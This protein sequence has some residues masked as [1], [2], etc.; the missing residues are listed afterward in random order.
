MLREIM[1]QPGTAQHEGIMR[2]LIV[3]FFCF[4]ASTTGCDVARQANH[5]PL[6]PSSVATGNVSIAEPHRR[7]VSVDGVKLSF[8]EAGTGDPVLYVHGVVTTSNIFRQYLDAYSP[9]F[10]GIAVDLRGYGDSEKP[11][12]GFTIKQFSKD[13]IALIDKLG[14]D[15]A[16][17]VGVSMGG[18][19]CSS[20]PWTI[21]IGSEPWSWF[22]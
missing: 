5:V 17:W 1:T 7:T 3:L 15:K 8:L 22:R 14:I 18:M 16:V 11:A 20:L 12:S 2:I 10:R 19:I 6:K 4:I 9:A 21:P 13:L